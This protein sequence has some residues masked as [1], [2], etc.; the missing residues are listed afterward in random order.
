MRSK[1]FNVSLIYLPLEIYGLFG[2]VWSRPHSTPAQ[3]IIDT[4]QPLQTQTYIYM[5]LWTFRHSQTSRKFTVL[6]LLDL[7]GKPQAS[8]QG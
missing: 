7:Y 6:L 1:P 2:K 8:M 3:L 4:L 5:W